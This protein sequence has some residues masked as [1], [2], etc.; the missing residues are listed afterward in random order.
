MLPSNLLL[1]NRYQLV[2][3][4][5]Q[6]GM[7]AVYE[8]IDQRLGHTVALKQIVRGDPVVFAQEAKL[9]ARLRHPALPKVS[10]HFIDDAGQFLVMDFIPGDDL[11]TLWLRRKAELTPETVLGWGDQLLATLDYLH[12]QTPPVIHRDIKPANLKLSTE[13]QLILLDF[14]LA[15][16]LATPARVKALRGAV[17]LA[18]DQSDF[19][20]GRQWG[21]EGLAL[22]R[23]LGEQAGIANALNGL[24]RA[25]L[26]QGDFQQAYAYFAESLTYWQRLRD[27]EGLARALNNLASAAGA[28]SNYAEALQHYEQGLALFQK[29]GDKVRAAYTLGNM[30]LLAQY[31]QNYTQAA[32][33]HQQSLLLHQALNDRWGIGHALLGLGDCAFHQ[34]DLPQARSFYQKSL[35]I[36]QELGDRYEVANLIQA[37]AYVN[38]AESNLSQ[39]TTLFSIA[40]NLRQT[41]GASLLP[42]DEQ[43]YQQ[44][45]ATLQSQLPPL[46]FTPAWAAGQAMSFDDAIKHIGTEQVD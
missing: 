21:E 4:I 22:A 31:Q 38:L 1:Q 18:L 20:Q 11:A 41:L 10:D 7:G 6:G 27:D 3:K 46:L 45:L 9:L 13:G 35:A 2:R 19:A 17:N 33:L 23:Q 16:T 8:A 5:A 30:G 29:L 37:L 36:Q 14:G 44:A 32:T 24:G 39:A 26:Y 42:V 12:N 15:H 34:Q 40:A 25:A 43:T 28:L